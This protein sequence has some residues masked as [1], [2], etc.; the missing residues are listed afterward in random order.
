MNKQSKMCDYCGIKNNP[1]DANYCLKCGTA[2]HEIPEGEILNY[3]EF[4]PNCGSR[5]FTQTGTKRPRRFF[6]CHSCSE[7]WRTIEILTY[8]P[9]YLV[10]A[11]RLIKEF[12]L[13]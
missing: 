13:K 11:E 2:F 1:E 5:H 9:N 12:Q 6:R 8:L 3:G 7:K 10:E 4:C